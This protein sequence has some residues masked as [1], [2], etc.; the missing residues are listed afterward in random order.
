MNYQEAV[1]FIHSIE[2]FGS[3]PGLERISALLE[4]M[5][6]PQNDLSI[7]H[8]AG[9]NGKGSTSAMLSHM[10]HKCGYKVGLFISPY[11]ESF[12]ERI[13]LNNNPIEKE[14]I[15]S[16]VSKIAPFVEQVADTKAGHPT[17]FEVVTAMGFEY[18]KKVDV[19]F[20][21]LE[22]GLGGTY[23]ATN[24]IKP[25]V[26]VITSIGLDHQ[27]IL[28]D[29]VEQIAKEKAGI[30]KQGIPV[31][32]GVREAAPLKVI[33]EVAKER[34]AEIKSL[35]VDFEVKRLEYSLKGQK[36]QFMSKE[37]EIMASIKFIGKH[38]IENASLALMTLLL[39]SKT[40]EMNNQSI[41]QGL[42]EAS[43]PG[44]LEVMKNEPLI[45]LDGAHNSQATGVIK[46]AVTELYDNKI[47]A[48]LGIL[49][50]KEYEKMISDIA[51]ISKRV[52]I[53][54]PNYYR[55]LD[56]KEML[57]VAKKY[58]RDCEEVTKVSDAVARAV[59]VAKENDLI[60]ITGSLYTVG[61]AR[62]Y[63]LKHLI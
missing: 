19:D 18:F 17:Q 3:R 49:S 39:L 62:T 57:D 13:Q 11:L 36:F 20:V 25:V 9:T 6:N 7:I 10:L 26:S 37:H 59:E 55:A 51:Q 16:L 48:V 42:E 23:D 44:R 29:T 31:V 53:T 5:N 22:V 12:N 43:W 28:G 60:L 32:T 21:I 58:C 30:I 50:D 4:L 61:E 14:E 41:V 38:Q 45:I 24:V 27:A 63:I 15:A 54:A 1:D 34:N 33:K 56:T 47:I 46:S 8:V 52:I 40:Y 2:I 35:G